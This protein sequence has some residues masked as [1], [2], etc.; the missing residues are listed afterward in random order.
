MKL[1]R[2]MQFLMAVVLAS[3]LAC[4]PARALVTLNDSH[5]RIYVSASWGVSHDSNVYASNGGAADYIYNSGLTLEYSRRAGWI[6]VNASVAVHSGRFGR[7]RSEDFNNPSYSLEFT[8]QSGRTTGALT[9]SAARES[10]AD[11]AINLRN[12]SWNYNVGLNYKYPI[13]SRFTLS[14]GFGYAGHIY[15]DNST[16]ANLDSY[17][18]NADLFYILPHERDLIAGY[19]YRLGRT[20]VD[21]SYADHS[22]TL[23]LGG[24]LLFG[25]NGSVR[26]GYQIRVPHGTAKGQGQFSSWT[27][28]AAV[29]YPINR[30]VTLSATVAKDFST[31]ATDSSVDSTTAALDLQFVTSKRWSFSANAGWGDSRFLGEK[32]RVILSLSPLLLGPNRHDQYVNWGAS[33]GY[34]RSEHFRVGFGYTW[35][36]N[37][38]TSDFSDFT[39]T[40]WNLNCSSRW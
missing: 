27:G 30:K 8:K 6:G 33:I 21:S 18:A 22:F 28:S 15:S 10:R 12:T 3:T 34:S 9:V 5:D 20:S 23:G 40:G 17:S 7:L 4:P 26:G 25:L 36:E 14:G 31:T 39:R 19:R 38:S 24:P 32:G 2:D 11:A 16:L 1:R 13:I 35:F 29:T 37:W